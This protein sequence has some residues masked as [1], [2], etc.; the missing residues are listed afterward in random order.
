MVTII[1]KWV[2]AIVSLD[3]IIILDSNSAPNILCMRL[4]ECDLYF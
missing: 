4:S 2:E 1:E 3:T